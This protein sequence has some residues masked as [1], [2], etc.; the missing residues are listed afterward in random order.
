MVL[1]FIHRKPKKYIA[2]LFITMGILLATPPIIP[3]LIWTEILGNIPLAHLIIKYT[4]IT[5]KFIAL[6]LTF[7][8]IPL[9]FIY[10][11]AWIYPYSTDGI[12]HGIRTRIRNG[13]IKY[14]HLVKRNPI[15]ILWLVISILI[16][17][18][19]YNLQSLMEKL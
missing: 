16:M 8:V 4:F 17:L 9:I 15:H 10:L 18:R 13:I 11:G 12:L 3:F 1:D 5:N 7:T 14:Y 2:L 6:L 19:I